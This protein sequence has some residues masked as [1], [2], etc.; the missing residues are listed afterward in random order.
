MLMLE[1]ANVVK[2]GVVQY[3]WYFISSVQL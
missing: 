1:L 3:C 2:H